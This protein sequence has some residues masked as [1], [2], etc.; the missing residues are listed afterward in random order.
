[1]GLTPFIWI[2]PCTIWRSVALHLFVWSCQLDQLK[3]L[4][5]AGLRNDMWLIF[6]LLTLNDAS[7]MVF[8]FG[9]ANFNRV[10][11]LP[12][13]L[14]C[15]H[16]CLKTFNFMQLHYCQTQ[17]SA[18]KLITFF[19]LVPRF[20]FMHFDP[21]LTNKLSISYIWLLI[22]LISAL[23]FMFFFFWFCHWF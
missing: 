16:N 1:M 4:K 3:M 8:N 19:I 18:P 15:T 22:W 6:S 17:L 13:S 21:Q 14:N 10:L 23:T 7:F 9:L 5:K 11:V 12:V 20:E 2:Q